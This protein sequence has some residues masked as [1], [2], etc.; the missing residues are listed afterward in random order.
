VEWQTV[1]MGALGGSPV[2]LVLGFVSYK[3]W[4]K[5]EEKDKT[6]AA[7]DLVIAALNEHRIAD[8]KA[9]AKQND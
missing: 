3:L 9:I 4:G 5:L 1:I 2:A 6:I 8:L 7:K